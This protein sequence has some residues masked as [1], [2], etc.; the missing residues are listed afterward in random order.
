MSPRPP[1]PLR[2]TADP[3]I[4][5]KLA[6]TTQGMALSLFDSS[7]DC[8]QL[9]ETDGRLSYMSPNGQDTLEID[10]FAAVVG[11]PWAELWPEES[12]VTIAL[13]V[14]SARAGE[15][16]RID[17]R[18]SSR[19]GLPVWFDVSVSPIRNRAGEVVRILSVARDISVAME[20]D[21]LLRAG[22]RA[23][24]D[25]NATL[26]DELRLRDILVREVDHRVKNSLSM[27]A[28]ILR[29]QSRGA[30]SD[31]AR[32]KLASAAGRVSTVARIHERLQGGADLRR[33]EMD[34]YLPTVVRAVADALGRDDITLRMRSDAVIMASGRAAALGLIAAE[35]ATNAFKHAFPGRG[36]TVEVTLRTCENNRLRLCVRDNG[37]GGWALPN[38]DATA[39]TKPPA[40]FSV[41]LGTRITQLQV[42]QLGGTLTCYSPLGGGTA[43]TLDFPADTAKQAA[44]APEQP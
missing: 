36:G 25:A 30:V 24:S 13:A 43:L 12:H 37:I 31:E 14:A 42:G 15:A 8:I 17:I 6:D 35:L 28:A 34:Q 7:P 10:D 26:T 33:V 19:R 5:Q 44:D 38:P 3:A 9:I 23:L 4:V 39:G 2:R 32:T 22:E 41:G 1:K 27:I 11:R 20:R 21:A 16:S 29:M 40:S 18:R